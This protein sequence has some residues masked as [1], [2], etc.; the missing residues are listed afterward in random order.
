MGLVQD[1]E[2]VRYVCL[3]CGFGDAREGDFSSL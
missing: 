3:E 1:G 2:G